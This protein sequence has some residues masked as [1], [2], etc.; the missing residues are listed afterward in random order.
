MSQRCPD[1]VGI[2]WKDTSAMKTTIIRRSALH[3]IKCRNNLSAQRT[4]GQHSRHLRGPGK[5][6]ANHEATKMGINEGPHAMIQ[7]CI[8]LLNCSTACAG[9]KGSLEYEISLASQGSQANLI[10]PLYKVL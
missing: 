4:V 6:D 8:A 10:L 7:R 9:A 1:T 5:N 3:R 2:V